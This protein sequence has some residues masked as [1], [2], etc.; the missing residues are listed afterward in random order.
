MTINA[1]DLQTMA[2]HWIQTPV[3][4]Y[5]G[6]DYGS[7]PYALLGAPQNAGIADGY[8]AKL[9]ADIAIMAALPSDTVGLFSEQIGVDGVNIF[10][11]VAGDF[12]QLD[13]PA[14]SGTQPQN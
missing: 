14:V 6:S 4:G 3:N 7:D 11:N 13:A 1:N 8:L 5:L 12:V 10:L 9:R 2:I